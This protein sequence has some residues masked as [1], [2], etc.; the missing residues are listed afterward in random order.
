MAAQHPIFDDIRRGDLEAVKQHVLAN[1]AVL[2]EKGGGGHQV[3]PLM[4]AIDRDKPTIA[5]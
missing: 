4:H 3:T 5:H 1:P 2:E